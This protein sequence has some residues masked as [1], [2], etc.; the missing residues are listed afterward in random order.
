MYYCY[1]FS[2]ETLKWIS[3]LCEKDTFRKRL[4]ETMELGQIFS[5]YYTAINTVNAFLCQQCFFVASQVDLGMP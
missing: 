2:V 3:S 5:V 1:S 4:E